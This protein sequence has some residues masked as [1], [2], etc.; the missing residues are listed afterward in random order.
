MDSPSIS[1]SFPCDVPL[2]MLPDD[3]EH[4]ERGLC[5]SC[6]VARM[7]CRA[8]GLVAVAVELSIVLYATEYDAIGECDPIASAAC[9]AP[10]R[11][12][13]LDFDQSDGRGFPAPA[14]LPPFVLH[15]VPFP[16][17]VLLTM[18]QADIATL[19]TDGMSVADIAE[20]TGQSSRRVAGILADMY[21]KAGVVNMDG[22]RSVLSARGFTTTEATD[23]R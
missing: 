4:G 9:P 6:P 2:T 14:I 10:V 5:R 3:I 20:H 12:F 17:P 1:L 19:V 8:T 16:A 23:G 18:R 22:L 13:I 7:V 15:F 21:V 11:R